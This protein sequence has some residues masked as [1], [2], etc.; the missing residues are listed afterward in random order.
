MNNFIKELRDLTKKEKT[1]TSSEIE[2][3]VKDNINNKSSKELFIYLRE[4][5]SDPNLYEHPTAR[6]KATNIE[7][8]EDFIEYRLHGMPGGRA[9]FG[10]YIYPK[11][12]DKNQMKFYSF[13]D[14]WYASFGEIIS[15]QRK[16]TI[17]ELKGILQI[18]RARM[19]DAKYQCLYEVKYKDSFDGIRDFKGS[20]Y[21]GGTMQ[22]ETRQFDQIEGEDNI[23][24]EES[25]T[26][27]DTI[28]DINIKIG[29][30]DLI[31]LG[32]CYGGTRT[33]SSDDSPFELIN[34][35]SVFK[36]SRVYD[37]PYFT[38]DALSKIVKKREKERGI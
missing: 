23:K 19:E 15:Y 31:K 37:E 9:G 18:F 7:D 14:F 25:F 1:Y 26:I 12:L 3:R 22:G 5:E 2:V 28:S 13:N 20:K 24:L 8:S 32:E 36:K 16:F 17:D 27:Y 29:Q 10:G 4:E 21:F 11:G 35:Y 34:V 30:G 33:E 6:I 38:K